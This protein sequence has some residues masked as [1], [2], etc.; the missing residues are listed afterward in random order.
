MKI[1]IHKELIFSNQCFDS[2]ISALKFLS[3]KLLEKGYVK[4][5]YFDALVKREKVFPTGLDFIKYGVAIPHADAEYINKSA[6]AIATLK[7]P[8]IFKNMEDKNKEVKINFICMIAL[9]ERNH[10]ATF[11]SDLIGTMSNEEKMN[12]ILNGDE[13]TIEE[14]ISNI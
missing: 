12:A 10:Q 7:E 4:S 13:K 14:I 6:L 3:D 11:L 1:P 8:V 9:N 5:S 2:D